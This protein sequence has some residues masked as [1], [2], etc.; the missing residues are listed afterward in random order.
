MT[1]NSKSLVLTP[2]MRAMLLRM[3]EL[4]ML[5]LSS[6][7]TPLHAPEGYEPLAAMQPPPPALHHDKALKVW[8]RVAS[9]FKAAQALNGLGLTEQAAPHVATVLQTG[10]AALA[11]L[12]AVVDGGEL[13]AHATPLHRQ[14]FRDLGAADAAKVVDALALCTDTQQ[15]LGEVKIER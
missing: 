15:A 8:Q 5:T 12:Y 7:F 6:K 9:E 10:C 13:P 1:Q 4:G 2:E 11:A 3:Q 14:L